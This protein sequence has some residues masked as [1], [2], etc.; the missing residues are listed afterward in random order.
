MPRSLS[1]SFAGRIGDYFVD[2]VKAI[3]DP[4]TKNPVTV[5]EGYRD[6]KTTDRV[7]FEIVSGASI[8]NSF[9]GTDQIFT[10]VYM[11]FAGPPI[12]ETD[13]IRTGWDIDQAI[14]ESLKYVYSDANDIVKHPE[15]SKLVDEGLPV[16]AGYFRELDCHV[17][18]RTV[19]L[20]L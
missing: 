12:A 17:F 1:T 18:E 5:I 2:R 4:N 9:Q 8:N 7:V 11:I 10:L 3:H 16:Y 15:K 6:T 19:T 20:K 13:T 14:L